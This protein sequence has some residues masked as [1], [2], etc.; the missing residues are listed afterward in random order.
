AVDEGSDTPITYT[1]EVTNTSPGGAVDPLTLTS[2]VDDNG[3]PCDAGDDINLLDGFVSGS[4]HGTHYV[5]GDSDGDYQV[6]S[7]ATWTFTATRS[8]GVLNAGDTILNT[9]V[10]HAHDD[11][12]SDDVSD[13]DTATVT[14]SHAA[15]TLLPYTTLFRSAVDEGSD[16][17]I[18]Y[19]YE[20]T[21]TSPGGA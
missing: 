7:D 10:V 1:Y 21:N 12:S 8:S 16:T 4:N 20:V 15:P 2:L 14:A 11:D 19:T 17:P 3:T 18:T 13:T 9:V 6:D 5:S